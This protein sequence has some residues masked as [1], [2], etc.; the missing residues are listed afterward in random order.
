M[1]W[2]KR[3]SQNAVA[4]KTSKRMEEPQIHPEP[5]AKIRVR[6]LK[7]KWTVTVRDEEHGDSLTLKLYP[8]PWSGRYVGSDRQEY[9]AS[10]LGRKLAVLLTH[11]A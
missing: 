6:R 4:A 11:A 5:S 3:H 1:I 8:L 7:A 9:S 10:R 2:T